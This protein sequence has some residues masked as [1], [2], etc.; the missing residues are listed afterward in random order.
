MFS[1]LHDLEEVSLDGLGWSQEEM[2]ELLGSLNSDDDSAGE[3]DPFRRVTVR[4][5][6]DDYAR[7]TEYAAAHYKGKVGT[8]VRELALQALAALRR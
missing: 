4:V 1:G 8:A 2:G 5:K 7:L 3:P 6:V